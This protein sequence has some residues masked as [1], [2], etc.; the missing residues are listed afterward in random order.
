M[1]N[2]QG[3]P[4]WRNANRNPPSWWSWRAARWLVVEPR[5]ASSAASAV[6]VQPDGRIVVVGTVTGT[7]THGGLVRYQSDGR[8]DSTFGDG[9]RALLSTGSGANE[10]TEGVRMSDGRVVAAG[11]SFVVG[12]T[13][14]ALVA[15]ILTETTTDTVPGTGVLG[16]LSVSPNPSG[17]EA[18]VSLDLAT[19][20]Y[21]RVAA[22][23][24]LG[25]EVAILHD[26]QGSSSLRALRLATHRLTPGPYVI[27][28]LVDGRVL[29]RTFL[30]VR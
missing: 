20:R 23:D 4:N 24:A 28:A 13:R 1:E 9:G 27:R 26:G 17:R 2:R 25:R 5:D 12:S 18:T 30:V 29:T 22:Y 11:N 16:G 6:L 7:S 15:R 19:P 3:D 14:D 8:L 21:A 10:L